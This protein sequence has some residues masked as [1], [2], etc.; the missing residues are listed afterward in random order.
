MLPGIPAGKRAPCRQGSR[1]A[2]SQQAC[3]PASHDGTALTAAGCRDEASMPTRLSAGM[4]PPSLPGALPVCRRQCGR[5]V[6]RDVSRVA[7]G[8][9]TRA[10]CASASARAA[11]SRAPLPAAWLAKSGR[12]PPGSGRESVELLLG[13][14]AGA[15]PEQPLQI[16]RNWSPG[17]KA[18]HG[19]VQRDASQAG[20]Q[21]LGV[22]DPA[23]RGQ[24]QG[25]YQDPACRGRSAG[26]GRA[27]GQS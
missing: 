8:W 20:R 3:R 24:A 16:E 9:R 6:G 15:Q 21:R 14:Q 26:R 12:R 18:R 13:L 11:T 17:Q 5:V 25:G 10:S 23:D 2:P 4:K 27:A 7:A 19:L 1:W 22:Q